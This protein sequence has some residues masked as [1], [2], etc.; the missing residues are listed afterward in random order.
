MRIEFFVQGKPVG[1]GS[2][3]YLG[4]G[5]M[6]ETSKGLKAW[7]TDIR[8]EAQ[9]HF[10]I[11]LERPISICLAFSYHRPKTHRKV[12]GDLTS[13]APRQKTSAP[14]LDKLTRAVGDALTG[15]AYRDDA[16]VVC[17]RAVKGYDLPI[18]P[19]GE[20]VHITISC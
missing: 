6:V 12:N 14:D 16:Q 7:R 20:G 1:Q 19:T 11:P 8:A 9:K 10:P 13:R 15:V 4:R 5:V 3:R 18:V 17:L 2:K